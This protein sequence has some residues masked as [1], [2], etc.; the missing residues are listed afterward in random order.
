[1]ILTELR[2]GM[3]SSTFYAPFS[4]GHPAASGCCFQSERLLYGKTR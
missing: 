4:W 1:M 2:H 3:F